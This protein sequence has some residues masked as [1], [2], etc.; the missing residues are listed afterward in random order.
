[1]ASETP[2]QNKNISDSHEKDAS[3]TFSCTIAQEQQ[4]EKGSLMEVD[5]NEEEHG[6]QEHQVL[7]TISSFVSS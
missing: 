5:T 7:C 1:M 3:N 2:K 6:D 4:P